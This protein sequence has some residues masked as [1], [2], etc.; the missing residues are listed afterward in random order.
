MMLMF[1]TAQQDQVIDVD[2]CL[3]IFL[4][5]YCTVFYRNGRSVTSGYSLIIGM[6]L[7]CALGFILTLIA[8]LLPEL[9]TDRTC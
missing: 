9:P 5:W 2:W 8:E 7:G 4:M 3:V 1:M 6:D